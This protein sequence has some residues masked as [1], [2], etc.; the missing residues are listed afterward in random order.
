MPD[1][2]AAAHRRRRVDRRRQVHAGQL[3]GRDGGSASRACSGRPPARRCWCTTP[4]T[5]AGST[6]DR[7][8]PGLA[9]TDRATGDPG[10]LQL[11]ADEHVPQGLAILD[12]PDIDSVER[13][14]RTLAAELLAAA[15]LW[16][17]VT[18]AARYADQ[19]PWDFLKAAAERSTAVAIV[20]DRTAPDAVQEVSGHLARMLTARGLRDSPLFTVTEGEVSDDGLLPAPYVAE[21]R[22]WLDLLAADANARAAVVKQTLDGAVRSL[23]RRTHDVADAAAE[24]VTTLERLRQDVDALLRRGGLPG[25]RG[26]RRRHPAARRGAGPLAGV[27]RHRRAAPV[28]GDQGR[29]APRPAGRLGARQAAAGRTGHGGGRVRAGDADP[30]ARR[31][32]RRAGRD[33]LAVGDRGPAPAR[34]LRPG[35]R[36]GLARLP[37]PRRARRARLAAR[38]CWRWSAPRART[39][40]P[41]PGSWPSASTACRW[42]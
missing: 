6:Q 36:P 25:G 40:A 38:A 41:R 33:L 7:I 34:G 37:G 2:G 15:D 30:R 4:P 26:V 22:S 28:P 35:P 8:L 10:A 42:R 11:V 18:S 13:A 14:N 16:L 5:S 1:R 32:R 3:P 39:S 12:A 21:I 27:R 19:V 31:E 9:R 29:P 24:Q 20:L 23:A 17:F